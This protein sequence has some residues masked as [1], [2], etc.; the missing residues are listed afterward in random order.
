MQQNILLKPVP[1]VLT[2]QVQTPLFSLNMRNVDELFPGFAPGD[3]AVLYGSPS[4]AS[5]T[6]I[7]CVRAQL[8]TQLGG[9]SSNVFFIDGGNTFRL[10]LVARLAQLHHLNPKEALDR[11]QIS[12][13]FTAYQMTSLILEHLKDAVEKTNAKLVI[14]ADIA[15]LFLDKD[16]S[17]EEAK[18]V[19]SQVIAY[20]QNFARE[21]QLILIA[22]Y[23]PRHHDSRNLYL[24]NLTCARAN[25][26]IGLQ[27]T[28]YERE[29]NLEKHPRFVLGSAE[30][31]SNNL[32]LNDFF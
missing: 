12:R 29:F 7:L 6:S 17:D 18:R 14:I 13:A 23:P 27:Q 5:L 21:K 26:V 8:P 10:N 30:F 22:T 9:L 16:L 20:L 24:Q 28:Q 15:G 4:V 32:T 31:P 1:A 25:I 2:T 3:F 19:Y 11:I